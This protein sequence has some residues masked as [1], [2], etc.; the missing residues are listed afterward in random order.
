MPGYEPFSFI[1]RASAATCKTTLVS[2]HRKRRCYSFIFL[3]G[4]FCFVNF[5]R[6]LL[7]EYLYYTTQFSFWLPFVREIQTEC[8]FSEPNEQQCLPLPTLVRVR[9]EIHVGTNPDTFISRLKYLNTDSAAHINRI[10]SS[11]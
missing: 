8:E 10:V 6:G 4:N 3:F 9:V 7:Q 5:L 1:R 2:S 11:L